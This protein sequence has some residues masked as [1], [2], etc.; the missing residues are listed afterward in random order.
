MC[1]A[2]TLHMSTSSFCVAFGGEA[3]VSN[4]QGISNGVAHDDDLENNTVAHDLADHN[5]H[6]EDIV[7]HDLA[8]HTL[9][10]EDT[11]RTVSR[12]FDP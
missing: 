8:D 10:S 3:R 6:S 7:A 5:L 11:Y 4:A 9:H 2:V 12:S 1:E